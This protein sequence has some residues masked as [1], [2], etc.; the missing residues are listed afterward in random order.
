MVD[1]CH[2]PSQRRGLLNFVS[3]NF[4]AIK[5]AAGCAVQTRTHHRQRDRRGIQP[6]AELNQTPLEFLG[7]CTGQDF[8]SDAVCNNAA[9]SPSAR[10]VNDAETLLWQERRCQAWPHCGIEISQWR[11]SATG[12]A[13]DS[14]KNA[15]EWD[16]S[17]G[18]A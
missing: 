14:D 10:A 13:K 12:T 16:Y 8:L 18:C 3:L 4:S 7:D 1:R 5:D 2:H 15:N 9:R 11:P 17:A 6:R